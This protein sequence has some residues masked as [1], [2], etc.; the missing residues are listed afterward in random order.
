[1]SCLMFLPWSI[2]ENFQLL[3]DGN[4]PHIILHTSHFLS[5]GCEE[6]NVLYAFGCVSDRTADSI[7]PSV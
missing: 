2:D 7:I 1:M 4:K 5:L 6:G 3:K